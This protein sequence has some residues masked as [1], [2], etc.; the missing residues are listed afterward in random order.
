MA[1][2]DYRLC[3]VCGG[4]A[5]YDARLNYGDRVDDEG[6]PV[7]DYVGSWRVVCDECFDKGY[8]AVV[9]RRKDKGTTDGQG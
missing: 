4:K 6:E 9:V 2:S 1:M 8:E 5:F 7:P 3:D